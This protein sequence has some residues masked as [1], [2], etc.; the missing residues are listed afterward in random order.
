MQDEQEL[1]H[2]RSLV[3]ESERQIEF[4]RKIIAALRGASQPTRAAEKFLLRLQETLQT[5][6]DHRD[7]M[8]ARVYGLEFDPEGPVTGQPEARQISAGI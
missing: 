5:R 7:A 2:V 3:R 6:R 4:Q 8:A 1:V